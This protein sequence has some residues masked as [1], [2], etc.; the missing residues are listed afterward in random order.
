MLISLIS[1]FVG[2]CTLDRLLTYVGF[3]GV[4]YAV[5]SLH[6]AAIVY[7]TV[8]D[9]YNTITDFHNLSLYPVNM[10][11]PIICFALHFYHIALY[12]NKFR[13]DD[14]LH[15]ILMIFVALPLGIILPAATLTGYSLFFTTGL[16]GFIDYALL[17]GVRNRW[18]DKLTE[19]GVNSAVN[20]WIRSPGCVSQ[21]A[22]AMA[23][24]IYMK[25]STTI[26][27]LGLIPAVL[28][29]WNGQYFMKQIII[30]NTVHKGDRNG[31]DLKLFKPSS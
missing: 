24:M 31:R 10:T 25:E 11:A 4:Y 14:W 22:Y 28:T 13:F 21:M 23:H 1:Y 27:V 19:K 9:V 15:H 5:H 8:H 17:F 3:Q 18:V 6:N 26:K 16:P 29:G 7:Y 30:D 2:F 12:Y 20:V